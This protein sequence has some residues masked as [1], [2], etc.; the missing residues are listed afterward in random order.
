[1][2]CEFEI[3]MLT[4][5]AADLEAINNSWQACFCVAQAQRYLLLVFGSCKSQ[6]SQHAL[7]VLLVEFLP[8][9]QVPPLRRLVFFP[10]SFYLFIDPTL[11]QSC[12]HYAWLVC[13]F[14]WMKSSFFQQ[15][16]K[17]SVKFLQNLLRPKYYPHNV[18]ANSLKSSATLIMGMYRE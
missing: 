8:E 2:R 1:M 9:M 12:L 10:F 17:L 7:L 3:R 16:R 13:N 6:M 14:W 15:N 5:D 4:P 18:Y 11:W